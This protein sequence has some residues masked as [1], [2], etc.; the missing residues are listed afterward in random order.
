MLRLA[1]LI[2]ALLPLAASAATT[3]KI[4]TIY[5]DGTTIVTGLK[6]AG[7]DI[8]AKTDGRV[9]LKVYPGGVMGDD[10]AVQRKIRIGQLQG[11]VAQGGAF[12]DA[13]EDSQILNVP[14]AFNNY[15]EVDAVRAELDPVIKQG[16]EEGGWVTFGLIDGGFAYIM[17]DKPVKSITDLRDQKLWLPANDAASAQAAKAFELSP[18]MLNIGAVLTSL[19]TGAINAFAAP[20]VA[21]LTLQWYSRVHYVTDMP[22]LY[23]F[24]LL[25][26]QKRYFDRISPADQKVVREVLEN[27]FDTLDAESR[28]ENLSAFQAVQ[29][30]GL[31]I[32]KPDAEQLKEWKDYA[33]RATNALVSEGQVSQAML[34]RLNGIL[35]KYREAH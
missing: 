19:Q 1:T 11:Q 30:Q 17:S 7:K 22:L 18:I 12:A 28:K 4:S 23:T 6:K 31:Q 9:K 14:L 8:A 2:L 16:L 35:A 10:R 24:G 5:P 25:G 13:Y 21:A 33:R 32:V 27:T 20:P 3:L 26:V 29:Q 15:D 34:D